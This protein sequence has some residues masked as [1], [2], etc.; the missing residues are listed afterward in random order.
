MRHS[1]KNMCIIS[2]SASSFS[3][4]KYKLYL[5]CT[6]L[7]R[8]LQPHTLRNTQ[9]KHR[10]AYSKFVVQLKGF[11][12]A[13]TIAVTIRSNLLAHSVVSSTRRQTAAQCARVYDVIEIG[14]DALGK[15][16]N[17]RRRAPARRNDV[18]CTSPVRRRWSNTQQPSQR[19]AYL[20]KY[21]YQMPRRPRGSQH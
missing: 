5:L 17:R 21:V 18:H 9:K 14:C 1:S 15:G 8:S 3:P 16:P 10:P 7:S 13:R 12:C 2:P 11:R 19:K 6:S 20:M 4:V